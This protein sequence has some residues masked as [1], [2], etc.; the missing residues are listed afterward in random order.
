MC[1]LNDL[2]LEQHEPVLRAICASL[3]LEDE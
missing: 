1:Q 2:E 3:T